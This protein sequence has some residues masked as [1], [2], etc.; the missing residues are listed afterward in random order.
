VPQAA[1]YSISVGPVTVPSLV[2]RPQIVIRTGPNQVN[3]EEFERWAS[4]LREDIGRIVAKNLITLLGTTKVTLFPQATAAGASY[5]VTID[6]LHFDS[7]LGKEA[8][9]DALWTLTSAKSGQSYSGRITLSEVAQGSDY[10][11]LVAAHSRALE[12]LSADIAS[13]F[14]EIDVQKP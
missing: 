4:P 11:A 13:A 3:V 14:R 7:A 8:Y 9:L 6:V 5:R 1:D 2:D 10:A 12:Q